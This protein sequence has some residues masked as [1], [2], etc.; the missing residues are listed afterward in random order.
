MRKIYPEIKKRNRGPLE[1]ICP[2]FDQNSFPRNIWVLVISAIEW[3]REGTS[4]NCGGNP[5]LALWLLIWAVGSILLIFMGGLFG[6]TNRNNQL[7]SDI[8]VVHKKNSCHGTARLPITENS[9]EK[10]RR[11]IK[12]TLFADK[13]ITV[14]SLGRQTS[15]LPHTPKVIWKQAWKESIIDAQGITC[16]PGLICFTRLLRP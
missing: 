12:K 15:P 16:P 4:P 14:V 10:D 9:L 6:C 3:P 2:Y 5:K 1:N 13:N 8:E 11:F 7:L